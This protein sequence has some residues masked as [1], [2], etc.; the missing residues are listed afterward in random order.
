MH[1]ALYRRAA[2]GRAYARAACGTPIWIAHRNGTAMHRRAAHTLAMA[3][4]AKEGMP[5]MKGMLH[6]LKR[7]APFLW[8]GC[9]VVVPLE[10]GYSDLE[11]GYS[12]GSYL[13]RYLEG[14]G[15]P[16]PVAGENTGMHRLCRLSSK[17][18]SS[19]T[20]AL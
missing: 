7:Y 5:L 12:N 14:G 13:A 10:G 1:S 8:E 20:G 11:G 15:I 4:Q 18:S 17:F 16:P 9:M 3:G 19:E 2:Y 6:I